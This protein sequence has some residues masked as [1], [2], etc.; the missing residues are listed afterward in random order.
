MYTEED[1]RI[2]TDILMELKRSHLVEESDIIC[3]AIGFLIGWIAK[4]LI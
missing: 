3:G 2:A 1:R 4:Y